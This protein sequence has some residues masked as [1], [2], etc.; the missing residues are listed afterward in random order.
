MTM[1]PERP[2]RRGGLRGGDV[3]VGRR[4]RRMPSLSCLLRRRV[5][6]A[7]LPFLLRLL[8]V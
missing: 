2:T 8:A 7:G 6:P 4:R 5:P 1:R 3:P